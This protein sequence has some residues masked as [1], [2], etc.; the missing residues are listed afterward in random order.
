M[1]SKERWRKIKNKGRLYFALTFGLIFF[2]IYSL[3]GFVGLYIYEGIISN[4]F[5]SFNLFWD[6]YIDR[7]PLFFFVGAVSTYVYWHD[8]N[9]KYSADEK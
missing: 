1:I 3:F 7:T 4:G 8:L 6:S 2:L 9:K 5:T